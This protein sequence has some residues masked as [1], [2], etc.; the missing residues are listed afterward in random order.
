[1]SAATVP[2]HLRPNKYVDRKLFV[3]ALV[4]V[5]KIF[6][7]SNGLYASMGG[8]A[9]EDHRL[10]HQAL[11]MTRLLSI[12]ISEAGCLRQMFNRPN[13]YI[14]CR[15]IA[16]GQLTRD[17]ESI[18]EGFKPDGPSVVWLDYNTAERAEQLA[19][20]NELVGNM[21]SRDIV[22]VTMNASPFT[23]EGA[24]DLTAA[25]ELRRQLGDYADKQKMADED[26]TVSGMSKQI[27]LAVKNAAANA[28]DSRPD[29]KPRPIL[30]TRYGDTN[31]TM[32]TVTFILANEEDWMTLKDE[33]PLG[34][35][36][37]LAQNWETVK[38]ISVPDLSVKEQL[39]L[40]TGLTADPDEE[41]LQGLPFPLHDRASESLKEVRAF[42]EHYQRYPT[43]IPADM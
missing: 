2:F 22:K 29:L 9:M 3:E 39:H 4:L 24:L 31:Q 19:E 6:D 35:W 43:F 38:K 34:R 40:L 14:D 18:R 27:V 8:R 30:I 23:L 20:V 37:F 42:I 1:M 17:F 32:V 33:S 5:D 11:Q 28:L 10:V 12:E 13:G 36:P 7:L 21:A 26:I 16:A 15:P 25:E 41:W